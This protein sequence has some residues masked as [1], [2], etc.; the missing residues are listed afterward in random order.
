MTKDAPKKKRKVQSRSVLWI[1]A[2]LF[3]A[4]GLVR[5][6]GETGRAIAREV[7]DF[8]GADDEMADEAAM[9]TQPPGVEEALAAIQ[10]R[11]AWV[12][13]AEAAIDDRLQALAVAEE[14]VNQRLARLETAEENLRATIALADGAAENDLAR[15]TSV[16][17]NMK[18]KDASLLFEEMAPDFAAGFLGRMRPDAAAAI[19]T[20]LS[21]EKAY[22]ISVLLAGRNASV[23]KQ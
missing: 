8:G 16:Y 19:M 15:L 22:T 4:S 3:I 23:P 20:G 5:L 6:G 7:A 2:L 9:C 21:P 1:V 12:V 10:A 14:A 17:E 11:E 13:D 18:P